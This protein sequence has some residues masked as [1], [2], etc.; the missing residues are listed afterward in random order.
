MIFKLGSKGSE[1]RLIQSFLKSA[2]YNIRSVTGEFDAATDSATRQYQRDEGLKVDGII[3]PKTIESIKSKGFIFSDE[4]GA[5]VSPELIK[6]FINRIIERSKEW[7]GFIEIQDNA[8]WDDPDQ[9]GWQKEDSDRLESY[10][11]K[12]KPWS[13]GAP[14]CS[15]AVGAIIMMALED[16]K[17]STEKF[18]NSWSAHVMTNVRSLAFKH[19]LSITPS[20]GSIWLAKFGDT[21]SGHTGIVIDIKGDDLITLE[22]NT[23]NR[24]TLNPNKQ[25]A[26]NGFFIRKFQKYGRGS[27]KTQGFLSAENILKFFVS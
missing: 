4:R 17:L 13:E 9:K 25:R 22:G 27:L 1:V 5:A 23:V 20:L 6:S 19:I 11:R 7:E 10:L 12:I 16:C 3:G 18:E 2:G 24:P 15:A 26:G 14:Y 21:D 8:A